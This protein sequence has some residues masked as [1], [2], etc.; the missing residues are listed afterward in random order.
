M[1]GVPQGSNLGPFLFLIYTYINDLMKTMA[2]F[3]DNILFE[4]ATSI[5]I[6]NN[7]IAAV[8]SSLRSFS[9]NGIYIKSEHFFRNLNQKLVSNLCRI[10]FNHFFTFFW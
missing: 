8:N 5:L 7:H 10:R 3:S 6:Q 4:D 9:G 1:I 2:P